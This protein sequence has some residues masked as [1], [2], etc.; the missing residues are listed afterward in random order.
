M[1]R[2]RKLNACSI[3]T[4]LKN[5]LFLVLALK[6]SSLQTLRGKKR[7]SKMDI[8]FFLAWS[9]YWHYYCGMMNLSLHLR[10]LRFNSIYNSLFIR[11]CTQLDLAPIRWT[12]LNNTHVSFMFINTP[13][14]G[15]WAWCPHD[16]ATPKVII[17]KSSG[18]VSIV[19]QDT[20]ENV[21][22]PI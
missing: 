17:H 1:N 22:Y 18:G 21:S 13:F 20:I 15:K 10:T 9:L 7:R 16:N 8:V 5:A 12:S 6:M 4:E 11:T 2:V 19:E 3:Y 14:Y